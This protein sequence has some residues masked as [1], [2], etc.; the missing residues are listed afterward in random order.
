MTNFVLQPWHVL[1]T[2]LADAVNEEQQ[3]VVEYLRM[4]NQVDCRS[5]S[6]DNFHHTP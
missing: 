6:A 4:E 3:G 2:I 5:S 1:V